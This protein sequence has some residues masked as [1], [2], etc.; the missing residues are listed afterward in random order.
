MG[1]HKIRFVLVT[2]GFSLVFT[3]QAVYADTWRLEKGQGWTSVSD[4]DD[5]GYAQAVADIKQLINDGKAGKAKKAAEKLKKDFPNIAK[6]DFDAF[7]KA[8]LLYAEGKYQK[9]VDDL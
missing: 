7:M 4:S 5:G 2:I 9:A 6:P 1:K 8:E 3:S